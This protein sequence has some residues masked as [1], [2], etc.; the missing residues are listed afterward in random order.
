MDRPDIPVVSRVIHIAAHLDIDSPELN[1]YLKFN[2]R[3]NI[4]S[5]TPSPKPLCKQPLDINAQKKPSNFDVASNLADQEQS[6][7][8]QQSKVGVLQDELQPSL[9]LGPRPRLRERAAAYF[10]FVIVGGVRA[11]LG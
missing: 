1:R 5:G 9:P 4:K 8:M 10:A 3:Q 7:Q 2:L 6:T 11:V